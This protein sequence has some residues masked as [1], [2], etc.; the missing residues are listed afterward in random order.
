MTASNCWCVKILPVPS[1]SR[2]TS[3]DNANCCTAS[4]STPIASAS[5]QPRSTFPTE[6][7]GG[8][9]PVLC[10]RCTGAS[11]SGTGVAGLFVTGWDAGTAVNLKF[12]VPVVSN[13]VGISSAYSAGLALL[14][15]ISA[16]RG[17]PK[18]PRKTKRST[19][20]STVV[21]SRATLLNGV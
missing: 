13:R 15:G 14:T 2:R 21:A 18:F 8:L 12:F 19:K 20:S 1:T 17:D 4:V 9:D 7:K 6:S 16:F 11:L 3:K 10:H 5:L